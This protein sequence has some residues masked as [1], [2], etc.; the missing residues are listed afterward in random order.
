MDRDL[1]RINGR[2]TREHCMCRGKHGHECRA[3]RVEIAH[4]NRAAQHAESTVEQPSSNMVTGHNRCLCILF[5]RRNPGLWR[6]ECVLGTVVGIR[7]RRARRNRQIR[8]RNVLDIPA[9]FFFVSSSTAKPTSTTSTFLAREQIVVAPAS[10]LAV[11][12]KIIVVH[13]IHAELAAAT[14]S[15]GASSASATGTARCRGR[16]CACK[17]AIKEALGDGKQRPGRVVAADHRGRRREQCRPDLG[18]GE[19]RALDAVWE[20]DGLG[21]LIEAVVLGHNI[22]KHILARGTQHCDAL[23][24]IAEI[25]RILEARRDV[26]GVRRALV[27]LG[28]ALDV[29]RDQIQEREPLV[30][31]GVLV[32]HLNDLVVALAER[33][34]GNT[35][36]CVVAVESTRRLES[37]GDVAA[38]DCEVQTGLFVGDKVQSNLGVTFAL[39]IGDD[40]LATE[41]AAAFDDAGNLVE[42]LVDERKLE[43][44]LCAIDLEHT[45][46]LLA[47]HAVHIVADDGGEIQRNLDGA[48]D[49]RVAVGERILEMVEGG[50][51]E[52]TVVVPCRGLDADR[53]VHG[54]DLLEGVACNHVVVLGDE[55][56]PG[57][58]AAP[59]H[60]LD[61]RDLDAADCVLGG[62]IVERDALVGAQQHRAGLDALVAKVRGAHRRSA[63]LD[64]LVLEVLDKEILHLVENNEAIACNEHRG[65]ALA[66]LAFAGLEAAAARLANEQLIGA[67]V[68]I[69]VH[70]QCVLLGVEEH[71]ARRVHAARLAECHDGGVLALREAERAEHLVADHIEHVAVSAECRA[72]A[73]EL[74]DHHSRVVARGKQ[75]DVGVRGQDP[76]AI[77][78]SAEGLGGH[79]AGNVP[80]ADRLVL[81]VGE[82]ELL[83]GVEDGARDIVDMAA[84]TVDFPCLGLV[85]APELDLAVVGSRDDQ[86]EGVVERCP[87]DAAVVALEHVLDDGVRGAKD[88]RVH[89]AHGRR[90]GGSA[91]GNGLLAQAREI[92]DT[93]GLVE[94]C[95]DQQVLL[96][97]ELCA[98]HIVVVAREHRDADAAL[99]VGDANGLVVGRGDDPGVLVVEL[100]RADVVQMAQQGEQTLAVLVVPHLDLVVV[101]AGHK[102]RLA[103]VEM[104]TAHRS[105]VLLKLVEL[106]A[107]AVVPQLNDAIVQTCQ[108]PAS[109]RMERKTLHSVRLGLELGEHPRRCVVPH[110]CLQ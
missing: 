105:F 39:E 83:L 88:V 78:V 15:T 60:I 27:E 70:E 52:H 16:C 64:G 104:H 8:K 53:L 96:G 34:G 6:R 43:L 49:A 2:Q 98:H 84:Q 75:I 37:D 90:A 11:S 48:Q 106:C 57:A 74:E 66:L 18:V 17:T 31:F 68:G 35:V 58:V 42:A 41:L 55:R 91:D 109:G 89:V 86:R 101:A 22:G 50:V 3:Q 94:R 13:E 110:R 54:E 40:G 93:H 65:D 30:V 24:D 102:Q 59:R 9:T 29:A 85:H 95:A 45:V 73:V 80:D 4:R 5:S 12:T 61:M 32:R 21:K 10:G 69:G 99:P 82:N 33:L 26:C 92:P 76:E 108:D 38:L 72:L 87:V 77:G 62:H 63:A 1:D 71:G 44:V 56:D 20:R 97:V 46:A 100:D 107:H 79:A 19:L 47:V 103:C 23:F 51:D 7:R 81:G 36:P 14:T 67:A 28:E 25:E